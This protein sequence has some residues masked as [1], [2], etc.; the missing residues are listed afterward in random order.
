VGKRD[1]I[2]TNRK[3]TF[4]MTGGEITENTAKETYFDG[5]LGALLG[6]GGVW[7]SNT[8]GTDPATFIMEDGTISKNNGGGVYVGYPL[9][10]TGS[11]VVFTMN[12]GIISGNT[13]GYAGGGVVA[14]G[15]FKMTSG[16]ISG[17]TATNGGGVY[18]YAYGTFT[19]TAGIIYGVGGG[20]LANTATS[21]NGHAAAV[22][23]GSMKRNST[24]GTGTT[25]D[26]TTG[27][28]WE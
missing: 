2:A 26:S 4:K 27:D 18:M 1:D 21:G 10:S 15:P 28:G 12:G 20:A 13:N 6:G 7:L 24:A 8:P 11:F 17:N 3:G 22:Y 16:T 23:S 9:P 25:M 14:T 19:K 5:S